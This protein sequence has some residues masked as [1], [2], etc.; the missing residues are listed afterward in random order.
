MYILRPEA[1]HFIWQFEFPSHHDVRCLF[2][3]GQLIDSKRNKQ[4]RRLFPGYII[5]LVVSLFFDMIDFL[6]KKQSMRWYIYPNNMEEGIFKNHFLLVHTTLVALCFLSKGAF[7]S[8]NPPQYLFKSYVA[9][10]LSLH[11]D[12]MCWKCQ[13][14]VSW[15]E[16]T[17][18]SWKMQHSVQSSIQSQKDVS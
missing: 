18:C 10:M 2:E 17:T 3:N 4:N 15:W 13:V 1:W 8:H 16:D 5:Q 9:A 12:W 11:F 6:L 14:K 7:I